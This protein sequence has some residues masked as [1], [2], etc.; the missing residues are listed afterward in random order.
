MS[1]IKS[2]QFRWTKGGAECAIK[3]LRDVW[4]K[5]L[6]FRIK[7]HATA[8]LLNA[9]IFIAVLLVSL[10][11]IPVWWAFY[12]GW[13]PDSYFQLA[14]VFLLGFVVI[15]LVYFVANLSL[16]HYSWRGVGRFIWE[17]PLF[18]SVSMG[19]ALHNAQAVWE[20]LTGKKSPFVRTPK[21]NLSLERS[22]WKTNVY[23]SVQV[24]A[25]TYIEA[26]FAVLFIAI[27]GLSIY[28]QT[29][30][31]LVFHGMLAIGYTLVSITSFRSYRL[32]STS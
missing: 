13:I 6:P 22:G 1:A 31:M 3:H 8:H 27:V 21:Y 4:R 10:S 25:T 19:L 29:Y 2:Q 24:P 26:V 16:L 30:E 7:F 12:Q 17:L 28:T 23:H 5:P 11:S 32:K 20:G 15:A 18:L 9:V 14:A